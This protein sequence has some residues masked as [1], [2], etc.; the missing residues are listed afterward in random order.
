[1]L[2]FNNYYYEPEMYV[3]FYF[4]RSGTSR[5]LHFVTKKPS[6]LYKFFALRFGDYQGYESIPPTSKYQ[7]IEENAKANKAAYNAAVLH[8]SL[9]SIN[10]AMSPGLI[11]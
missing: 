9:Q 10:A 2:L 5:V 11:Q 7:L 8:P 3:G 1:M 4:K 6:F